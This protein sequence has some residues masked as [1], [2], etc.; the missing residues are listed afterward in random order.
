MDQ[1]RAWIARRDSAKVQ[2][3]DRA[4][5]E[6]DRE[7]RLAAMKVYRESDQGKVLIAEFKRA[8]ALRNLDK[9]AAHMAVSNAVRD[10]RL[11]RGTCVCMEQG[12]CDGR[13]E[14]H[15]PDYSRKLDVVWMCMHHHKQL[16]R[17]YAS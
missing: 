5:Y 2:A 15:H 8:W 13:I 10:G 16:H 11:Q 7:K 17:T 4:R 9:T 14:A 1:R 12:D 3:A 6:R